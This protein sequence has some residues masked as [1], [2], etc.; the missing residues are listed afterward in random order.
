MLIGKH[1]FRY[2]GGKVGFL[3]LHGLGGTPMELRFVAQGLSRAGHT[4][5]CPQLAG[6]CSTVDELGATR[7]QDWYCSAERVLAE[8]SKDCEVV[9]VGGLSMGSILA[10]HLA[11]NHPDEVHGMALYAPTFSL[12]GW[13]V[14]WRARLFALLTQRWAADLV[15][16]TE[17]PPYG[18]KD[19]R[20]RDLVMK[21]LNSGDSSLAGAYA[22]PGSTMLELRWLAR[23]VRKQLSKIRQ[24]A[25][26]IHPRE[27]DR[28]N[29][30]NSMYLARKLGGLVDMVVLDDSYHIVTLD[31][32]R[33]IV[34][35][36]T[37]T[38]ADWIEKQTAERKATEAAVRSARS[39][40]SAGNV[41]E[42]SPPMVARNSEA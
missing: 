22:T 20:V 24:P 3:L 36:R 1:G 30:A 28:S 16:F 39:R 26:I 32:Q 38:F 14:P 25:L 33:H 21:A 8:L 2:D 13:G 5:V 37:A 17:R 10:L 40:F 18:I 7:W 27:D 19:Q 29:I 11:A 31:K 23:R 42:V 9:I 6:H 34:I 41:V 15:T 35:E 12:D 4:V